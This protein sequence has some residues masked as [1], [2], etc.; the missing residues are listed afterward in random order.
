[1][2]DTDNAIEIKTET[3][4][5][6]DL[7]GATEFEELV[8][9]QDFLH[10]TPGTWPVVRCKACGLV[11]TNPRPAPESI[12]AVYP[13]SYSP[14]RA[15]HHPRLTRRWKLQQ[16]ALQCHWGYPPAHRSM[17]AK[18]L[19]TPFLAWTRAKARNY[20]L[21]P[22]QGAGHLL[23]Y[24]CAAGAY[25]VRMQQRGWIPHGMDMSEQAVEIARGQS[26]DVHVG[27]DATKVFAAESMDAMT[28]WHVLEHVPSPTATVRQ[29]NEVLKPGGLLVLGVPNIKCLPFQWFGKYWFALDLPRHVTH[30]SKDTI[31]KLMMRNGFKVER[32]FAQRYGQTI[33][34]TCRYLARETG[35]RLAGLVAK[36]KRLSWLIQAP[37]LLI[38]EPAEIVVHARKVSSASA[39]TAKQAGDSPTH[40]RQEAT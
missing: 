16:W 5:R 3:L 27:I 11:F 23:D 4:A 34:P 25:L 36:S 10:G 38:G 14:Y 8:V 30:F 33:Q 40:V 20:D 22:F 13:S 39:R 15:K 7:C 21:F 17:V 9:G 26:L 37:S 32:I 35:S 2:T 18:L 29:A 24:G 6:C 1:M 31:G 28:L 19:S 12:G